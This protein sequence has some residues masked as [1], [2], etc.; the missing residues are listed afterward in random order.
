MVDCRK[1]TIFTDDLSEREAITLK[2]QLTADPVKR[3][4]P[5]NYHEKTEQIVPQNKSLLLKNLSGI[6]ICTKN[7]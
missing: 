2:K 7:N 1:H 5:L 6:E 4:Y 3:R